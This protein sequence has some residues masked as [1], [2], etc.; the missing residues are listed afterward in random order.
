MNKT[1]SILL[2]LVTIV[3]IFSGCDDVYTSEGMLEVINKRYPEEKFEIV[4]QET[5]L[6]AG[7]INNTYQL[8]GSKWHLKSKLN[9][10]EI[11]V[12]DYFG[13]STTFTTNRL[14]DNYFDLYYID[15]IDRLNDSRIKLE[16]YYMDEPNGIKR[17]SGTFFDAK[18]FNY[19]KSDIAEAI[20]AL[21]NKIKT[22]EKLLEFIPLNFYHISIKDNNRII[23]SYN[24]DEAQDKNEIIREIDET[25]EKYKDPWYNYT[26]GGVFK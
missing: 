8:H 12:Q 15:F 19:I 11:D 6:I 23:A 1:I 13:A 10:F 2:V 5:I 7:D 26:P 22:D 24:F 16:T 17:V 14:K 20:V 25:L 18:D 9:G 3:F 4:S 21:T